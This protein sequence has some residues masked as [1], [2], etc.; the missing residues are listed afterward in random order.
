MRAASGRKRYNVLGA[1]D[2][3]THRP[4]RVT[5]L[6]SIHADSVCTLLR[7]V[8][9]AAVGWPITPVLDNARYQK[10]AVVEALAASL[11]IELLDLPSDSPNLNLIERLWRFV[12]VESLN[13]TDD[14]KFDDFRTA[15]DGCLD[16]LGTVHKGEMETLMTHKFQLFEDVPLLAA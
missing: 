13:S 4:V 1:L 10:C 15:I 14:E 16:G 5:N 11:K 6:G 3:V 7:S 12:R 8:A 9:G 2:A